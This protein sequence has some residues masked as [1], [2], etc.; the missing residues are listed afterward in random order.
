MPVG[1]PTRERLKN[2]F[3]QT[4][5]FAL[6]WVTY[7]YFYQGADP[8]Q[9][10]RIFLTQSLVERRSLDIMP[11]HGFTI[12]KAELHGKFFCD[13]APGLSFLATPLF[14]IQNLADRLFGFS[15]DDLAIK[16]ARLH[17][18]VIFLCGLS[19]VAATWALARVLRTFGANRSEEQLLVVGYALG[20]LV[21]PFSTALFAHQ[22]VA[23]FLIASFAM[24]RTSNGD[25]GLPS[26][27]LLLI[28]FLWGLSII[29]EYPTGLLVASLGLYLLSLQSTWASRARSALYVSVGALVPLFIHSVY[30]RAAFG[31]PFALPYKFVFEPVFRVHHEEGLLGINPPTPAGIFGVLVSRYRGLFFFCPFLLL[32]FFG[33][34][35]WIREGTER[36]ELVLMIALLVTYF[37]F[38]T[39]YYAWDGGGSTGPRHMIPILPFLVISVL[40]FL[41]NGAKWRF[42]LCL[43][44]VIVSIG[45]MF[46][47]TAVLIHMPEGEVMLSNPIYE[48]ILP[49]F[50]R[51]ELGLNTQDVRELG[52]RSD[53]SYTLGSLLGLKPFSSLFV[54]PIIW[55]FGYAESIIGWIRKMA[56][57]R[58]A[59]SRLAD[60]AILSGAREGAENR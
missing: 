24:I 26:T 40:P 3:L 33:I 45:L 56:V 5:F 59:R 38:G 44:L 16:R 31:S 12:D 50:F 49:S 1:K 43:G 23:A 10:T 41:R 21:F 48:T 18:L 30:L 57:S 53:A 37:I 58:N 29:S 9:L 22:M 35:R 25:H 51:H 7:A 13:K 20:T 2:A 27:K 15:P 14:A 60:K 17:M 54:I 4:R 19:G 32:S 34:A 11:Y 47:S 36:R 42:F 8:N 28:G 55:A 39:S 52:F 6:L 46:V